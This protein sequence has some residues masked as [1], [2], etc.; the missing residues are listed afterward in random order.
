MA[1]KKDFSSVNTNRVYNAIAEA[2]AEPEQVQEA[3]AVLPEPAAQEAQ[4]AQ[5]DKR[6]RKNRRTYTEQEAAEIMQT[7]QTAGRKGIKLARINLA[8]RPDVYDYVLTMSRV[9]GETMT[10]F[11]DKVL[12]EHM[13]QHTDIYNKAIEFRN[14][15]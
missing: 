15:L 6:K 13:E 2:T 7:M 3:A 9:R 4:E 12:R 5:E 1:G 10:Q 8:F 14:S 11:I